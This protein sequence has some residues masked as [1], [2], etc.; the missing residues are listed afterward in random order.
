VC[1]IDREPYQNR[2]G[3]R[4]RERERERVRK[5]KRKEE[6]EEGE[7]E[8]VTAPPSAPPLGY[9]RERRGKRT[10]SGSIVPAAADS[11]HHSHSPP[12]PIHT[13][14]P[15]H[16]NVCPILPFVFIGALNDMSFI[17][18]NKK[19]ISIQSCTNILPLFLCYF[20]YSLHIYLLAKDERISGKTQ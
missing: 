2:T 10:T 9:Y 5:Y 3:K 17:F 1:P 4:N 13:I 7:P 11:S 15:L 6:G 8:R 14:P 18:Q 12:P 20:T 16:S 19:K